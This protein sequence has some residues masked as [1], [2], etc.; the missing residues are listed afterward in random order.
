M[1]LRRSIALSLLGILALLAALTLA[2]LR[3]DTQSHATRMER[4]EAS[5]DLRRLVASLDARALQVQG[6]LMSWSNW[7]ALHGY[8]IQPSAAFRAEELTPQTVA[9]AG[10]DWLSLFDADGKLVDIVEVPQ[11]DGSQPATLDTR[12]HVASYAAYFKAHPGAHGCGAVQARERLAFACFSPVLKSDGR[13]APAGTAVLGSWIH[14]NTVQLVSDQ[15]GL[16]FE[17][18]ATPVGSTDHSVPVMPVPANGF[19][20]EAVTMEMFSDRLELRYPIWSIFAKPIG[21]LRMQWPR[22]D[23]AA[24]QKGLATT[25]WVVVALIAVCGLLIVVLLDSLVVRRLNR[26]RQELGHIVQSKDWS[27]ALTVHGR[28]EITALARNIDAVI[29]IVRNQVTEL[30]NLSNTDTLTGLPNRRAFNHRLSH[31]LAQRGRK[32]AATSL[33][34]VDIDY[35]KR[36]ND[37]YGHPAGD[38][39]LQRL[40]DCFRATLRRELDMPARLGGEEFGA[41]L[42][43]TDANQALATAEKLRTAVLAMGLEHRAGLP[44]ECM[45]ISCAVAEMRA[46]DTASSLYQRA[47]KALYLAKAA[48]RNRVVVAE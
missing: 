44:L 9:V 1:G 17:L 39:A 28:D 36:Y 16:A 31:L 34:L 38:T 48:G 15:T 30:K 29:G 41:L 4:L 19:R 11:A 32:G 26:L 24:L 23:T 22:R 8:L 46:G 43:Q 7:T 2:L 13:G 47:D 3:W 21:E 27:G 14:P 35:F 40:A 42:E 25:Q 18:V 6:I 20:P 45:T 5:G 10:A 33:L 12:R 37:T